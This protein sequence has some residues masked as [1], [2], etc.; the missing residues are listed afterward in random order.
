MTKNRIIVG[1]LLVF[2][3]VAGAFTIAEALPSNE[4]TTIYYSDASKTDEV[5]ERTLLCSGGWI[6]W[7]TTSAYANKYSVPCN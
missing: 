3:L 7:G 1:L 5:G 4:V 2:A 6:K